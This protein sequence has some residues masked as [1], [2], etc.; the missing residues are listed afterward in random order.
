MINRSAE[1]E[2]QFKDLNFSYLETIHFLEH[3]IPPVA[4]NNRFYSI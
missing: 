3:L 2:K 4:L 1:G